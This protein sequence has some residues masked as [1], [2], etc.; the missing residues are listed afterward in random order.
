MTTRRNHITP[1]GLRPPEIMLGGSLDETVD[2]WTFGCIMT[3][4]TEQNFTPALLEIYPHSARYFDEQDSFKLV[5]FS[6]LPRDRWPLLGILAT[7]RAPLES[8]DTDGAVRLMMRC[9]KLYPT[10]R[11]WARELLSD[12]WLTEDD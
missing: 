7:G 8:S 2:I 5:D 10:E 12:P 4:F 3:Y 6:S 11:P 9:L 1:L